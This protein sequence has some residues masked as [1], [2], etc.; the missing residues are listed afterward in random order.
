[1]QGIYGIYNTISDKWYVGQS[2]CVEKRFRSHRSALKVG[3]HGNPHLQA[4]WAAY[5][6]E[7]FHFIL[8]EE[9]ESLASVTEREEFWLRHKR[10]TSCGVYNLRAVADSN[11]GI[12]FSPKAC[13]NMSAAQKGKKLSPTH[14]ANIVLGLTG[15]EVSPETRAKLSAVHAGRRL[16]PEVRANMSAGQKGRKLS[17]EHREKIGLGNRGKKC[18]LETRT[19]MS[20]AQKGRVFSLEHRE[21]LSVA[22]TGRKMS[23]A[24]CAK[25]SAANKG[26]KMSPEAITR[27][28]AWHRGRK[29]SPEVC[30]NISSAG[31]ALSS[32]QVEKV[33]TLKEKGYSPRE[34]A[35]TFCVSRNTVYRVL[36]C[37][38]VYKRV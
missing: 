4:A 2:A 17:A 16:P 15:R 11:Y 8:L 32:E 38:G 33:F 18:S 5:G 30:A 24:S 36:N 26:K 34:I 10:A 25:I 19:K 22:R 20:D 9:V 37:K 3:K 1:M 14:I 31:R 12:K 21:K 23:S 13:A 27:T 29:R 6:A 28:A 35:I 7:A